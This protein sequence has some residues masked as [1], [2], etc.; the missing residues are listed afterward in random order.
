MGDWTESKYHETRF[1]GMD[2]SVEPHTLDRDGGIMVDEFNMLS[3]TQGLR[4]RKGWK[5]AHDLSLYVSSLPGTPKSPLGLI[6]YIANITT[7]S[8]DDDDDDT[9]GDGGNGGVIGGLI[10]DGGDGGGGGGG[11]NPV[12]LT[13]TTPQAVVADVPFNIS[14]AAS[15]QYAGGSAHLE[16]DFQ[17][18]G[19]PSVS[20]T[21]GIRSGWDNQAWSAQATIW[22]ADRTRTGVTAT[23]KIGNTTKATKNMGYSVADMIPSLTSPVPYRQQFTFTVACKLG[24]ATQTNYAGNGRGVAISWQA[25][26]ADDNPV[27]CHVSCSQTGWADG[28][29]TYS[30]R[31]TSVSATAVKLKVIAT[32]AGKSQTAEATIQGAGLL[33]LPSSLHVYGNGGTMRINAVALTPSSLSVVAQVGGQTVDITDYLEMAADASRID[34]S[35]GWE[36]NVWEHS[37]RAKSGASA[38]TLTLKLMNGEMELASDTITIAS[39]LTATIDTDESIK[40]GENIEATATISATGYALARLPEGTVHLQIGPNAEVNEPNAENEF[41]ITGVMEEVASGSY[42]VQVVDMRDGTPL[43][44]ATVTVQTIYEA[45]AEAIN[46]RSLAMHGEPVSIY[47][48]GG[49]GE[50]G[51]YDG[52]ETASTLA[53]AAIAAMT[54]YVKEIDLNQGTVTNFSSSN[55]GISASQPAGK[56]EQ[57]W[58]ADVYATIKTAK[59]VST[60]SF[61]K[62]GSGRDGYAS[63]Q[64]S[65]N[66]DEA[67]DTTSWSETTDALFARTKTKMETDSQDIAYTSYGEAKQTSSYSGGNAGEYMAGLAY[68]SMTF[69]K[70]RVKCTSSVGYANFTRTV[71]WLGHSAKLGSNFSKL[72]HDIPNEGEYGYVLGQQTASAG[73]DFDWSGWHASSFSPSFTWNSQS[74]G[75]YLYI[76]KGIME[77]NFSHK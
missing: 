26:D 36:D 75:Y 22:T 15:A 73:N 66:Y 50:D 5:M 58:M 77:F 52:S 8:E 12:S 4:T 61:S 65:S 48:G 23:L 24:G 60:T 71:R 63:N 30:A 44:Q 40:P 47:G 72:G 49:H 74:E 70:L 7:V 51:W 56:T 25:L 33:R 38:A 37:V 18:D 10:D 68:C 17:P 32:Y 76:D 42:V 64:R 21:K 13:L 2:K 35:H 3:R 41:E 46:E 27:S 54:G 62:E 14:A 34:F 57:Q 11:S 20:L 6:P 16:W 1:G 43:A 9:G 39:A 55:T 19:Q 31:L 69:N 67:T 45:L 59:A 53:Q 28:V 29:G